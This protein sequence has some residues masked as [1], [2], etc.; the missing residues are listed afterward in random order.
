MPDKDLWLRSTDF[1]VKPCDDEWNFYLEARNADN[2]EASYEVIRRNLLWV[3]VCSR[4]SEKLVKVIKYN[5]KNQYLK[6]VKHFRM[7]SNRW[8]WEG[9]SSYLFVLIIKLDFKNFKEFHN[10]TA[11]RIQIVRNALLNKEGR[12]VTMEAE[13]TVEQK[14]QR[15][16]L[17]EMAAR[18]KLRF[19]TAMGALSVEDLYDLP[20]EYTEA[21]REKL[22]DPEREVSLD[23]LAVD[24]Y[25]RIEATGGTVVSFVR[26][27]PIE[28]AE[29]KEDKLR[30]DILKEVISTLKTEQADKIKKA[31]EA[32]ARKVRKKFLANV[33]AQRQAEKDTS[34]DLDTLIAEYEAL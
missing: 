20:L 9:L 21:A 8:F 15:P 1:V 13:V 26:T 32:E 6:F 17:F 33:I 11:E 31:E 7:S 34:K 2:L 30:L 5:Y 27:K 23:K 4:S 3:I 16:N 24:T 19:F 12:K 22:R 14:E 10:Y 18:K 28:P 25:K 29:V